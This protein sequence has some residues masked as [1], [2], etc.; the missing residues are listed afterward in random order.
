MRSISRLNVAAP[1]GP[2]AG[3][4]VAESNDNASIEER[5]PTLASFKLFT[6]DA[7]ER[8]KE[9]KSAFDRHLDQ[10]ERT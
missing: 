7:L 5:L 9:G 6:L 3:V 1:T 10:G 8:D 4:D 2:L